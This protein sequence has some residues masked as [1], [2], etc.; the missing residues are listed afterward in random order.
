MSSDTKNVETTYLVH[1][2]TFMCLFTLLC[3]CLLSFQVLH[4]Y[5]LPTA[6]PG[7]LKSLRWTY[8]FIR[9]LTLVLYLFA[10]I[11]GIIMLIN[12]TR[13]S[14]GVHITVLLLLIAWSLV[15]FAT[16]ITLMN[17]ANL[18]PDHVNFDPTNLASDQRWCCVYG[19]TPGTE[20]LCS[21]DKNN[22]PPTAS[23]QLLIDGIFIMR[24]IVNILFCMMMVHDFINTFTVV[25]PAY[26]EENLNKRI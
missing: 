9:E 18:E 1:A 11:T 25:M 19:G 17:N 16:D 8:N 10:P 14:Q 24:F 20:F 12:K 2:I 15:M 22:C 21:V 7:F 23:S 5:Q 13:T 6:T 3:Y 4:T 26:S